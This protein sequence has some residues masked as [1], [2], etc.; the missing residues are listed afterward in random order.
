MG[1][2]AQD[3]ANARR[4][5]TFAFDEMLPVWR[6][7]GWDHHRGGF[8]ERLDAGFAPL[9]VA[10]RRL[11]AHCRQLYCYSLSAALTGRA[12]DRAFART[13]FDHLVARFRDPDQGGWV[14]SVD[15]DGTPADRSKDCYGL[16]FV[17]FG[18]AAAH[19]HL[20]LPAAAALAR[21][22]RDLMVR[23]MAL[24]IGGFAVRA[25][26]DWGVDD[27]ALRQNPNMHMLE[28]LLALA[29]ATGDP[30]YQAD[31]AALLALFRAHLFD[32]ATGTL[33]EYFDEAGK[34][35]RET[36]HIVEPGHQFEWYWLLQQAMRVIGD[37]Q[38][39]PASDALF[40]GG[41]R[42]GLDP[43]HGGV[44]DEVDRRGRVLRS[45]KRIWPLSEAVRALAWRIRSGDAAAW[46]PFRALVDHLL[47]H[48]LLSGGAWRE[49][50]TREGGPHVDYMPSTTPYHLLGAIVEAV[51]TL[52]GRP[53]RS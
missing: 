51:E 32:P 49:W 47:D 50:L 8:H 46:A 6:S 17:L 15:V 37:T 14:C 9:P 31:A 23:H 24:D 38:V 10:H 21:E 34:P 39:A 52:G 25:T 1:V 22:T 11:H 20:G 13:I 16:A 43:V 36:G 41:L 29:E 28:A 5:W 18:L 40:A 42:H 3:A 12:E 53:A 33:G 2:G 26:P 27:R 4:L 45:T 48:R 44:F 30:V 7:R 35:E 19:R